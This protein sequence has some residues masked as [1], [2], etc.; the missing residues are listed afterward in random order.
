MQDALTWPATL[1][2]FA[3]HTRFASSQARVAHCR[4]FLAEGHTASEL[5]EEAIAVHTR[6]TRPFEEARTHLAYGQLL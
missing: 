6:S 1:D 2:A 4:A 3:S 5:F